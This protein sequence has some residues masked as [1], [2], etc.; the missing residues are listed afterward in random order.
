MP[1][2]YLSGDPL[3]TSAQ[4]LAFGHNSI[5]RTELGALESAALQRYPAAFS[6]YQKQCRRE[7]IETGTYWLWRE[8]TPSLMFLVVRES[9]VSAAR[10]RFV[11]SAM[12]T[13]ARDY[14]RENIQSL[15]IAPLGNQYEWPEIKKVIE[16]WLGQSALSVVVYEKY[17]PG[18][19]ADER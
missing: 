13:L 11:Q 18:V 2:T 15:A 8:S 9:S 10:L 14:G 16:Q 4:F 7:R 19:Q 5:G 6:V 17:L 12:L 1:I 3:L